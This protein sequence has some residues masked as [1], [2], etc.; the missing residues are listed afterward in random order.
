MNV[1]KKLSKAM[2]LLLAATT[3]A[4]SAQAASVASASFDVS[5]RVVAHCV[6]GAD[7]IDL[8]QKQ[9]AISSQISS[10]GLVRVACTD[11]TP[12]AVGFDAGTGSGSS[13]SRRYLSSQ[14]GEL[15]EFNLYGSSGSPLGSTQGVNTEGGVGNG[16]TQ[17]LTIRAMVPAQ[18][19]PTPGEYRSTITATVYF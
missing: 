5:L 14:A 17:A 9:G 12:Y 13:I 18:K 4:G 3:V 1:A 15:V 11:T 6:I 16:K 10:A 7:D 19:T 2:A 8:G